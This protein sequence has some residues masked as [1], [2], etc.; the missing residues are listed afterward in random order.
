MTPRSWRCSTT[1]WATCAAPRRRSSTSAPTCAWSRDP[2]R[3]RRAD[4][5]VLPGVGA[6][7]EAMRR[8]RASRL[9]RAVRERRRPRAAGAR[10]SASACS[11]CSTRARRARA[12]PASACCRAPCGGCGTEPQGAAHRLEPRCAG[13][14][15]AVLAPEDE[16]ARRLDLLLRPLL[17]AASP[18]TPRLVLGRADHG[19]G[20]CAAA[21]REGVIGRPVPPGEVERRGPRP[22]RRAARGRRVRDARPR[23]S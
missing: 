4:G 20:F 18:R 1:G 19:V 3:G 5:V 9:D 22:A 11:C 12:R 23:S 10:A 13:Q 16:D 17:R 21:G 7:R 15:G 8:I 2:A 14:P 6:F